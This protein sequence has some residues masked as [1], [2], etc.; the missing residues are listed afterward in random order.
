MSSSTSD[1][2]LDEAD[3]GA[4]ESDETCDDRVEDADEG[5][6]EDEF[7]A[8]AVAGGFLGP[9]PADPGDDVARRSR[10]L[11]VLGTVILVPSVFLLGVS[12]IQWRDAR[13]LASR[14]DLLSSDADSAAMRAENLNESASELA[15]RMGKMDSDVDGVMSGHD[16]LSRLMTEFA[17]LMNGAVDGRKKGQSSSGRDAVTGRGGEVLAEIRAV[18]ERLRAFATSGETIV[19]PE[20]DAAVAR[21][22]SEADGGSGTSG[23]DGVTDAGSGKKDGEVDGEDGGEP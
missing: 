14:A 21:S 20:E 1:T 15:D 7:E 23:G 16:E 2:D 11:V 6:L 22:G 19:P 17:G 18:A 9:S 4:P 10:A 12:F 3:I 5:Y 8:E 13:N